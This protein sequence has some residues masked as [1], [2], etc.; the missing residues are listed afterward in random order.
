MTL[1]LC[2]KETFAI[3]CTLSEKLAKLEHKYSQLDLS[4]IENKF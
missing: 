4:D 2:F 3:S 1:H